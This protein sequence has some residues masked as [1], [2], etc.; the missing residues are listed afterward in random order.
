MEDR[1]HE[2]FSA[3]SRSDLA[4]DHGLAAGQ[5]AVLLMTRCP[6]QPQP[7]LLAHSDATVRL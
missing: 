7:D 6:K 1:S 2:G 4:L 5:K 3:G